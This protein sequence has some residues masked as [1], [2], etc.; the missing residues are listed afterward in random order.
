MTPKAITI[1]LLAILFV[2]FQVN[3]QSQRGIPNCESS[4][5]NR[6]VGW[7]LRLTLPDDIVVQNIRDIDHVRYEVSFSSDRNAPQLV[8]MTG[9]QVGDENA[10]RDWVKASVTL[11][12]HRWRRTVDRHVIKIGDAKG[13]L[14]NGN[15]WRHFGIAGEVV[16]YYNVPAAVAIAFDHVLGSVCWVDPK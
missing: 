13:K 14:R 8:G 4:S 3:A 15:Y 2:S 11:S 9:L 5:E 7:A 12:R 1:T 6:S 10:P 16:F